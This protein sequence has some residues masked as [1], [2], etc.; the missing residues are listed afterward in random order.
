MGRIPDRD[1]GWGCYVWWADA[2]LAR[3]GETTE[4]WGAGR[5]LGLYPCRDALCVIAGAPADDADLS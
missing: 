1:T 4:W 2:S 5:F 3:D